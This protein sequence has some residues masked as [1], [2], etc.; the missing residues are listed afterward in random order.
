MERRKFLKIFGLGTG[1]ALTGVGA[2]S[3]LAEAKKDEK[4]KNAV[5]DYLEARAYAQ[6]QYE[7]EL[8]LVY[9]D[10]SENRLKFFTM[11]G[12]YPFYKK[13]QEFK[14][15]IDDEP[16]DVKYLRSEPTTDGYTN[17]KGHF[18]R[19][20]PNRICYFELI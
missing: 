20:N 9:G 14:A 1:A 15:E 11:E 4:F 8:Y 17:D 5:T 12:S 18:I 6:V 2:F 13:G 10:H 3:T 16:R 7:K 19:T